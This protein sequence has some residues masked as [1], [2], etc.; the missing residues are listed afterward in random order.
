MET[1]VLWRFWGNKGFCCRELSYRLAKT[2]QLGI[3]FATNP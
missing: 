1:F 2:E 3:L